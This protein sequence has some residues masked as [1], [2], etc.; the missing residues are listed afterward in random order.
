METKV[1]H[2]DAKPN[3]TMIHER[4]ALAEVGL[5]I[6]CA[7]CA[8]DASPGTIL[9]AIHDADVVITDHAPIP[10]D[11]I[12]GLTRAL[13]IIRT[14]TGFDS[15]D[16]DA[17]TENGIIVVNFPDY[18]T[19]EVANHAMMFVLA[20][21]KRLPYF[22]LGMRG[23]YWPHKYDRDTA[24]PPIGTIYDETLGIVGLGRIGRQ[25]ALRARA[26]GMQI[27]ACDPYIDAYTFHQYEARSVS[28][29]ELL[30]VSDYV[31]LH[32]PLTSETHHL[33]GKPQLERMQRSAFL[34][35]TSRGAVVEYEALLRALQEEWISGAALDVFEAEPL[36]T[37]SPLIEMKNVVLT[38]HLAG[39]SDFAFDK[40]LPQEIG[41]EAARVATLR[42]PRTVANPEVLGHSRLEARA[43]AKP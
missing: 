21:A 43:A 32:T 31:T 12:E 26:F 29:E 41:A 11:V 9:E 39:R 4:A 6:I 34:I 22:D 20:C 28:L 8:A 17:A 36:E 25:V 10:R 13:A 30:E 2:V 3:A 15:V 5:E 7:G 37:N 19:L 1:V 42:L 14:G 38:P 35:N 27:L 23:G 33:I 40:R 24:L 18:S 16:I